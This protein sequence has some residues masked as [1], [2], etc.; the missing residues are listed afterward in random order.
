MA[1]SPRVDVFPIAAGRAPD[2]VSRAGIR[3][4]NEERRRG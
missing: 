1:V 4:T 3:H 2:G